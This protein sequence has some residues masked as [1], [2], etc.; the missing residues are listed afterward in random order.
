[1]ATKRLALTFVL[2]CWVAPVAALDRAGAIEAAKREMKGTCTAETPCKFSADAQEGKWHVRVEF[3]N[4]K[5]PAI[6]IFN[7]AGR[8]VGRVEGK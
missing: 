7:Q 1:M 2:A 5:S 6:L 4:R 3:T 8:V